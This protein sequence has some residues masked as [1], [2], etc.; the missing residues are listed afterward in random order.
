MS[1]HQ[2]RMGVPI[3]GMEWHGT[4]YIIDDAQP[5]RILLT[6]TVFIQQ[7]LR[8]KDL[9]ADRLT[10]IT[11]Y[12]SFML[13]IENEPYRQHMYWVTEPRKHFSY[14]INLFW[15]GFP[16]IPTLL[17]IYIG[18][19]NIHVDWVWEMCTYIWKSRTSD[20]SGE[21]MNCLFALK[22]KTMVKLEF[23]IFLISGVAIQCPQNNFALMHQSIFLYR[24]CW[25]MV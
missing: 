14:R 20:C 22:I 5:F 19:T 1:E 17:R 9:E 7:L 3:L 4:S 12:L 2:D 21:L 23:C 24:L 11:S 15:F 10:D 18:S 25:C 6:T 13:Q 8:G 16:V